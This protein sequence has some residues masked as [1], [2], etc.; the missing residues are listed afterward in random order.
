MTCLVDVHEKDD[1]DHQGALKAYAVLEEDENTGGIVFARHA[2]VARREGARIFG[3]GEFGAYRARR[4]PWADEYALI[5]DV[6]ASVCIEHGWYFECQGCGE[7]IDEDFLDS[8]RV[9]PSQ[10]LG[11]QHGPVYHCKTCRARHLRRERRRSE[12][13]ASA[14]AL[15]KAKVVARFGEVEFVT[16]FGREHAYCRESA[17]G[18]AVQQAFVSF[19]F[20]GMT[21]GPAS[22][23]FD[24]NHH[25]R[26]GPPATRY[27]VCSGDREAFEAW[28][29]NATAE[30]A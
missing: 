11:S 1:S 24:A 28:A 23:R 5:G 19:E 2:V 7:K 29:T 22:L 18:L 25:D 27:L 15:L 9:K 14:I 20:P 6:P 30:A 13:Q 26:I 16:G 8:R 21:I 17:G 4:A 12:A 3:D 10:V